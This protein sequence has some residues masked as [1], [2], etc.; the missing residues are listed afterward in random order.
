MGLSFSISI[1]F[2]KMAC[3]LHKQFDGVRSTQAVRW[4][5]VYTSSS[6]VFTSPSGCARFPVRLKVLSSSLVPV[7]MPDSP[8]G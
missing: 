2:I 3:G 8:S 1:T 4:R 5:A 6:L 7:A